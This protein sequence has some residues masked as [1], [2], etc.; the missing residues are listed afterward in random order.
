MC[1][2]SRADGKT[3]SANP[4]RQI[5]ALTVDISVSLPCE[6]SV[7]ERAPDSEARLT[8]KEPG[9]LHQPTDEIPT[10]PTGLFNN[11]NF[12]RPMALG[13]SMNY[14]AESADKTGGM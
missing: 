3:R 1:A 7:K 14:P 12:D 10:P 2:S 5:P 11:P 4:I 8:A 9:H 13:Q 6:C